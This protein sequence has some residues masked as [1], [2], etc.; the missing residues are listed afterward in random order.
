MKAIQRTAN[1]AAMPGG[2]ISVGCAD[3]LSDEEIIR[4]FRESG[5][6]GL[7]T[8]VDL[9]HCDPATIRDKGKIRQFV[10]ELTELIDMKR[11]GDPT[12]VHFGADEKV[13][14]F[15]MTQLI[16]TSLV[17]GHFANESNAAYL[18]IFSCKEYPPRVMADFCKL[19]FGAASSTI[20]ILFRE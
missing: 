9:K 11:F 4:R 15:S 17:S 5:A 13:A 10:V 2:S 7:Y 20:H 18:D 12:I 3:S 6:W 8:S 19:F 16:E 1:H 14:G